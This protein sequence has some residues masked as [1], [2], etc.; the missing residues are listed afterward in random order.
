MEEIH[1]GNIYGKPVKL[2]FSVNLNPLGVPKEAVEA[3]HK[4]VE[5][6]SRYPDISAQKLREAVSRFYGLPKEKFIFGNGA[7]ELFM[8]VVHGLRPEKTLIPVPSFY[9]YEYAAGAAGGEIVYYENN[10]KDCFGLNE[11][12]LSALTNDI[13][14]VFLANPN[15]PTGYLISREFLK[16]I[17]KRCTDMGI[18]VALDECF[19]EFCEDDMSFVREMDKFPNL[20]I[21]R[22]FTKIFS[23]PGVRLGYLLCDN[24]PLLEKIERQLPEWN[25]SVFAQ[26]AGCE[27]I[28]QSEYIR[29]TVNFLKRE[30]SFLEEGLRQSGLKVYPSMANFFLVYSER[31]L[32]DELLQRG[33]LIRDCSNFR[34][35][36]KGFYRMAIKSREENEVL[37]EALEQIMRK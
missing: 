6:C 1:G 25:I 16:R 9:G 33:I 10:E 18:Y 21:I 19:I 23:V 13:G 29:K 8:A 28:L 26:E 22:A 37:L 32:Y 34:G 35:L 36:S 12:F 4:A 14:L 2:D 5:D 24:K 27:C 15:N 11:D 31:P 17:L 20:I 7:S 30:R 3:L